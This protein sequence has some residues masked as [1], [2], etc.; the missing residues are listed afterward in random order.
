MSH[1][2][3]L[4]DRRYFDDYLEII[5]RHGLP[6]NVKHE[7]CQQVRDTVLITVQTVLEHALQEEVAT[8][9]GGARYTHLP[10]ARTPESTRSG[11]YQRALMT[12]YGCIPA[13]HVPKLRRG[14]GALPWQTI[15][16]YERCWGP[17]LDQHILGYCLGLSLRDL[18]EVMQVTLG[19]MM[20]LAACNMRCPCTTR[21][22]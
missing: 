8:Y 21:S 5:N 20:S 4:H 3:Q 10:V 18:Q 19:E 11:S 16:R 15:M 17:L 9:L 6:G 2:K 1:A 14:N 7:V 22:P 12:Q 13:L